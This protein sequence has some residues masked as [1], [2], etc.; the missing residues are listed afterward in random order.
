MDFKL[1]L[2]PK[3]EAVSQQEETAKQKVVQLTYCC[4]LKEPN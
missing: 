2:S 4:T 1:D 3:K